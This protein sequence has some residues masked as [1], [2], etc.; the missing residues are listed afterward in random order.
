MNPATPTNKGKEQP[1]KKTGNILDTVRKRG[2]SKS[3]NTQRYIPFAEIRND[4]VVLKNGGLRAVIKIEPLN[5]N[6]KSETEQQ[7]IILGYESFINTITFPVQILIRSTKVNIEPYVEHI[8]ENARGQKNEL[9]RKQTIAYA[10]FI[11]KI[12]EVADIMKK[13][14]YIIV[15][16][17]DAPRK[18]SIF[19]Q[20]VSWLQIDDTIGKALQ[21]NRAF[22]HQAARL[23]ERLDLIES[24]LHNIG[25]GTRR[26]QT[27]ELIKLYYHVYNPNAGKA[28]KIE[29]EDQMNTKQ[30]VL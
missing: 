28:Q 6:L 9:L 4:T 8:H 5:Y 22:N 15:P 16:L 10:T 23:R 30:T 3:A 20:F 24:G 2:K 13:D 14:F 27:M 12:V 26:L 29:R 21:R 25:L 7:G 19:T 1:N 17:D 11:E 18:K